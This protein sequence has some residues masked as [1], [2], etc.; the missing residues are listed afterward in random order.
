MS[1]LVLLRHGQSVWNKQNLFTGWT[2]VD[3]SDQGVEEARRAGRTLAASKIDIDICFTSLLKRA[4]KTLDLTLEEMDR[5]WLPVHKTWRLN[6]RHYGALQGLNKADTAQRYGQAQVFAWRRSWEVAPPPLDPDVATPSPTDRRY[7]HLSA[8]VM[9][10]SESLKQ[11]VERMLPYWTDM[12]APALLQD[13]KLLVVAH[14]N[15]LRGIVKVLS[16]LSDSEVVAFEIPTGQP[17][18]YE[19]DGAL[20]PLG[21]QFIGPGSGPLNGIRDA[22][23]P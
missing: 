4:I 10:R 6:E 17:L 14:G 22:A 18:V 16:R 19:L 9:P 12:I 13:R 8:D 7:A 23:A 3:L 11:T 15:S 1:T 20:R 21:R 5:M 2:D